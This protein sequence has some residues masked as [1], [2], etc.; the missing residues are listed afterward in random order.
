MACCSTFSFAQSTSN[1][2]LFI[3]RLH[4]AKEA[5]RYPD[6]SLAL[7]GEISVAKLDDSLLTEYFKAKGSAFFYKGVMDSAI[8]NFSSAMA[9]MDSAR[10]TDQYALV[11]HGLAVV[12]HAAGL[13][14][15]AIEYYAKS[16]G[17]VEFRNDVA[18]K[19]KI[20]N[21]LSI[22]NREL[23]NFDRSQS[24]LDKAFELTDPEEP[25]ALASLYNSRGQNFLLIDQYDSALHY[26]TLSDEN[27]HPKDEKGKAIGLNNIGFAQSLLGNYAAAMG[28]YKSAAVIREKIGDLHGSAWQ[29]LR[30]RRAIFLRRMG[31]FRMPQSSIKMCNL[32]PLK[33]ACWRLGRVLRR[34]KEIQHWRLIYFDN[35][36]G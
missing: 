19:M 31:S 7:L 29:T 8:A 28:Y 21:N 2:S 6:S 36:S 15:E 10:C 26:F 23:G 33:H 20:Y 35:T 1:A 4:E 12:L 5:V 30:W 25:Y 22:L 14:R 27:R 16:L 24:F 18:L 3:Q 9:F 32:P 34:K 17:C 13:R 11:S